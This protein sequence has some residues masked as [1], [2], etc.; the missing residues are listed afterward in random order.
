MMLT[1]QNTIQLNVVDFFCSL[2]NILMVIKNC[3]ICRKEP[4]DE[5]V[6]EKPA[7]NVVKAAINTAEPTRETD[8]VTRISR[9]I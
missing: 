4:N 2:V 6:I 1:L 7:V 9:S 3:P 5:N 8:C